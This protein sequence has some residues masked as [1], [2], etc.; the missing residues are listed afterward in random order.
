ME[1]RYGERYVQYYAGRYRVKSFFYP[2]P[3]GTL[4]AH[5]LQTSKVRCRSTPGLQQQVYPFCR[6][7]HKVELCHRCFDNT[8]AE[9]SK[10]IELYA[11]WVDEI[12]PTT[13][14]MIYR[15]R[16]GRT[17]VSVPSALYLS[18]EQRDSSGKRCAPPY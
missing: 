15:W 8:K 12:T 9:N 5:K 1:S 13:E 18:Y 3:P 11:P 14:T 10:E 4:Q 7:L 6:P 16:G 2:C 17:G